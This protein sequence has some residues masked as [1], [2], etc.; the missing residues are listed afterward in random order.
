MGGVELR[1]HKLESEISSWRVI[2]GMQLALNMNPHLCKSASMTTRNSGV[3]MGKGTKGI[4]EDT[5]P[6][7]TS[8]LSTRVSESDLEHGFIK[9]HGGW[10]IK[11]GPIEFIGIP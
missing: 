9:T 4:Q 8:Y 5:H 1:E 11:Q 2:P 6:I 3:K 10:K 7:H